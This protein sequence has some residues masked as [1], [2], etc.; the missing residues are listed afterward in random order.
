MVTRIRLN[1]DLES[2]ISEK[3]NLINNYE[4][5]IVDLVPGT[6]N[7]LYICT[8]SNEKWEKMKRGK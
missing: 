2:W 4:G 3:I 8:G 1:K 5:E 6:S 7:S